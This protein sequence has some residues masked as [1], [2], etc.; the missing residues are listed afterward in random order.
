DVEVQVRA[1]R[2][3]VLNVHAEVGGVQIADVIRAGNVGSELPGD[4]LEEQ[5]YGVEVVLADRGADER[6]LVIPNPFDPPPELQPVSSPDPRR[7]V[8]D[9]NRLVIED[10]RSG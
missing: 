8:A 2:D 10:V 5:R 9:L 3:A 4:S 7:V 6:I 1:D